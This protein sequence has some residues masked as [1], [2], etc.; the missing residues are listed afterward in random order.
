MLI[1]GRG[2][3]VELLLKAGANPNLHASEENLTPLHDAA[4][5]GHLHI[6]RLLVAA[7]ADKLA[8]NSHGRTPYDLAAA[9]DVIAVLE[10]TSGPSESQA[11]QPAGRRESSAAPVGLNTVAVAAWPDASA[12]DLKQITAALGRLG[13]AKPSRQVGPTTSH[14]LLSQG[15]EEELSVL[16]SSQL[17][18]CRLVQADWLWQSLH[19]GQLINT[20]LF[21]VSLLHGQCSHFIRDIS[22][23][24]MAL[25]LTFSGSI[26]A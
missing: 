8:R 16:L 20:D 7:G 25:L 10:S 11:A 12:G 15:Q 9:D 22:W 24:W 3:I 14:W 19:A 21:Q 4:S 23:I 13:A 6:V 1:L 17:V 5:Q 18:G 2:D 26:P